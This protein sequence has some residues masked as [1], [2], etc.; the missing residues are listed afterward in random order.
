MNIQVSYGTEVITAMLFLSDVCDP[1]W[2]RSRDRVI[3]S[4]LVSSI[5]AII[6]ISIF[7]FI[8]LAVVHKHCKTGEE[9]C[10]GITLINL[11]KG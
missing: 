4:G 8:Y 6:L 10:S 9:L 11:V 3:I 5:L 7:S 2:H 1:V